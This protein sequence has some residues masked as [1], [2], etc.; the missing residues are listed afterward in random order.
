M[1]KKHF[2]KIANILR[3]IR[4]NAQHSVFL[5]DE[6]T[7]NLVVNNITKELIKMFVDENPNFDVDKFKQATELTQS[8]KELA[9]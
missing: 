7:T 5:Q 8:E 1:T 4:A 9:V 2:I 6:K 3:N